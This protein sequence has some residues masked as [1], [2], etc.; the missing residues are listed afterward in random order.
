MPSHD[1][2]LYMVYAHFT[3]VICIWYMPS[4]DPYLYVV[5]AHFRS[6]ICVWCIQLVLYVL[7]F[8]F[9]DKGI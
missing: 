9:I 3:S 8:M 7:V 5:Y 4:Q 6:Q 2:Y 1:P